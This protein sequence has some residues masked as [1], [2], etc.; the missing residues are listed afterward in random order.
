MLLLYT[1]SFFSPSPPFFSSSSC[2]MAR[3]HAQQ[4]MNG[5]ERVSVNERNGKREIVG[6]LRVHKWGKKETNHSVPSAD[7]LLLEGWRLPGHS[8]AAH[9]HS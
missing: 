3:M 2:A 6:Y 8:V 4:E 9:I 1:F 7:Y 5:E